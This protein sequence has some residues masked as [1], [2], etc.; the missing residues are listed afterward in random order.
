[1]LGLRTVSTALAH[2]AITCVHR[3][4]P[5][6]KRE[7]QVWER[8]TIHVPTFQGVLRR[9][10]GNAPGIFTSTSARDWAL[11]ASETSAAFESARLASRKAIPAAPKTVGASRIH[12]AVDF[13]PSCMNIGTK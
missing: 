8:L 4:K 12:S 6:E 9:A 10:C 7:R 13:P 3:G 2:I 5:P 11:E 1:M